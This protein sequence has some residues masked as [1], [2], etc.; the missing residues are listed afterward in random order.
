MIQ[1]QFY[2][3]YDFVKK[4]MLNL[5]TDT[6]IIYAGDHWGHW[7]TLGTIGDMSPPLFE[8]L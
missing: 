6:G 2:F 5:Y 4:K 1:I 8:S 3:T 7:G